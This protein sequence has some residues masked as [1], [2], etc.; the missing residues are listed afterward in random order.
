MFVLSDFLDKNYLKSL[1]LL[2]RRHEVIGVLIYDRQA[3]ILPSG[4]MVCLR[5]LETGV[6]MI[7]DGFSSKTR[8]GFSR[9][10]ALTHQHTLETFSKAKSD[11]IELELASSISD[12]LIKYF[13]QRERRIR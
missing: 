7:F 8:S 1:Q 4:C 6:R 10:R 11:V 13:K 12:T 3:G 5:D 2:R 9:S